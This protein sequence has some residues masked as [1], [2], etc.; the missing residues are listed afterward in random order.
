MLRPRKPSLSSK[1]FA[2]NY[3]VYQQVA[4]NIFKTYFIYMYVSLSM[5]MLCV[6][7]PSKATEGV[8][9]SGARVPGSCEL[10]GMGAEDQTWSS[11]SS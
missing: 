5:C 7:V 4:C 11:E 2:F 1:T 10:P 9:S 6:Q 8:R 3:R